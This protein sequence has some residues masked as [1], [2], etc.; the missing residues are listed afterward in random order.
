M[1]EKKTIPFDYDGLINELIQK[2][3]NEKSLFKL[4]DEFHGQGLTLFNIALLFISAT[5]VSILP[6]LSYGE[7]LA[8][9][10][11]IVAIIATFIPTASENIRNRI[12]EANFLKA[13]DKFTIEK[14]DDKKRM[15]FEALLKIKAEN[16]TYKL[17]TSKEI[18]PEM[19]TKEKLLEKLYQS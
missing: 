10:I 18:H 16:P 17:T 7:K 14:K 15:I 6:D 3:D 4:R 2:I 1:A 5:A 9:G 11:A 12:V 13:I 8:I 19:F